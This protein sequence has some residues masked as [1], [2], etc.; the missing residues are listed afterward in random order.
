MSVQTNPGQCPKCGDPNEW[1]GT[2]CGVCKY[3]IRI[4][5]SLKS[6]GDDGVRVS[7]AESHD[8]IG[9]GVYVEMNFHTHPHDTAMYTAHEALKFAI[10]LATAAHEAMEKNAEQM[11]E[12]LRA[13]LPP[14]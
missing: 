1:N 4:P 13:A 9:Y 3:D 2:E 6:Y 11:R 14:F 7:A 12:D 10:A 8:E 5:W